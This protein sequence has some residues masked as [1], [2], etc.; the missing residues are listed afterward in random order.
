MT[1]QDDRRHAA[2]TA[3]LVAVP[4]ALAVGVLSVLVLRPATP[5]PTAS[6]T[7]AAAQATGAVTVAAPPLSDPAATACR[8]LI[9]KLPDQVVNAKRRPVSA[10]AEQN[11][12]WGDPPLL[13]ACGVLMPSI[14]LTTDVYPISGVCWVATP[15]SGGALWTTIDRAV[16]VAVTVPGSPDGSGQWVAALSPAIGTTLELAPHRPTGCGS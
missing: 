11:A 16:P 8:A 12:A 1:P 15:V 4:V 10:G 5:K 6:P 9:A 13:L 14:E 2:R 7:T 3:T